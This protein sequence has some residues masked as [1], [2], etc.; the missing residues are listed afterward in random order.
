MVPHRG[1][2]PQVKRGSTHTCIASL[3]TSPQLPVRRPAAGRSSP[4]PPAPR[5]VLDQPSGRDGVTVAPLIGT[6]GES[7]TNERKGVRMEAMMEGAVFVQTNAAHNEVIA[8]ER[9]ADG[10]LTHA[11]T[12]AT[13]GAG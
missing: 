2:Y 7:G 12:Y 3:L 1:E 10:S 13:G 8:F 5:G 9:G 6:D 11:G 4:A